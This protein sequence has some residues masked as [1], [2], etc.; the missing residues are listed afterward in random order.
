VENSRSGEI[1]Y[2]Y[3]EIIKGETKKNSLKVSLSKERRSE[4]ESFVNLISKIGKVNNLEDL[5][6][7]EELSRLKGSLLRIINKKKMAKIDEF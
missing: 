2:F 4:V 5:S 6:I 3:E 7:E 1:D